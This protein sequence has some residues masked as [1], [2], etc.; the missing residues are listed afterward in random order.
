MRINQFLSQMIRDRK[1]IVLVLILL[2]FIIF[3]VTFLSY[4][5]HSVNSSLIKSSEVSKEAAITEL[6]T[7]MLSSTD[8]R[9]VVLGIALGY[10]PKKHLILDRGGLVGSYKTNFY[11]IVLSDRQYTKLVEYF[12]SIHQFPPIDFNLQNLLKKDYT[13]S[14]WLRYSRDSRF[15]LVVKDKFIC[16]YPYPEKFVSGVWQPESSEFIATESLVFRCSNFGEPKN[17][18][19]QKVA[20]FLTDFL[21]KEGIANFSENDVTTNNI[22]EHLREEN[23]PIPNYTVNMGYDERYTKYTEPYKKELQKELDILSRYFKDASYNTMVREITNSMLKR[24]W[25][26]LELD[27]TNDHHECTVGIELWGDEYIDYYPEQKELRKKYPKYSDEEFEKN[28]L[29]GQV[30]RRINCFKKLDNF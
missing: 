2:L 17:N 14:S 5:H 29:G 10:Y 28:V 18:T 4:L 27:A 6:K 26:S 3:F 22:E 9:V 20:R 24:N 21:S 11:G 13:S 19:A 25:Y 12:H 30:K 7:S 16:L 23:F 1:R 15:N 8:T